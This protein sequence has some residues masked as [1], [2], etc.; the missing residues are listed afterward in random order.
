MGDMAALGLRMPTFYPQLLHA[1]RR[2]RCH[3]PE[4]KISFNK[5]WLV[6]LARK[7]LMKNKPKV[8]GLDDAG[9]D[10]HKNNSKLTE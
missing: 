9:T 6:I 7:L 4:K 3:S 5:Q 8:R 10:R 1:A 2:P